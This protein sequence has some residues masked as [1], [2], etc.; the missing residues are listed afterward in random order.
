MLEH[1]GED[2]GH[3]SVSARAAQ[4]L[5]LELPERIGHL[6]ERGTI[7]QGTRLALDHRQIMPPVIDRPPAGVMGSIDD[8]P[9]C[10]QDLTLSRDHDPIGVNLQADRAVTPPNTPATVRNTFARKCTPMWL[11]LISITRSPGSPSA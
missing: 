10:A 3:L 5:T 1:K 4:E 9:V 6:R 7:A 8:P 2:L 11:P